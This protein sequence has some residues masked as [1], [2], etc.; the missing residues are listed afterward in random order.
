MDCDPISASVNDSTTSV[1]LREDEKIWI[2]TKTLIIM[3]D[4]S[5][6]PVFWNKT[7]SWIP[8]WIENN[9]TTSEN[10]SLN[11][12]AQQRFRSDCAFAQSDLNLRWAQILNSQG[13]KVFSCGQERLDALV[14]LS[15]RWSH[16]SEGTFLHV[17][18]HTVCIEPL[19]TN[20]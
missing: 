8:K 20:K 17:T 3:D 13:C 18:A 2:R 7:F 10:V 6:V 11:M 9:A 1:S 16:I 15:Y 12:Y 19:T 5:I 4:A 14:D